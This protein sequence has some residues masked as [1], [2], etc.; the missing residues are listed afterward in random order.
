MM[1]CAALLLS[2]R[3][4]PYEDAPFPTSFVET[5]ETSPVEEMRAPNTYAL[6]SMS[7]PAFFGRGG[8]AEVEPLDI[9]LLPVVFTITYWCGLAVLYAFGSYV[10]AMSPTWRGPVVIWAV[11]IPFVVFSLWRRLPAEELRVEKLCH[12]I[13]LL[14]CGGYYTLAEQR[15]L[16]AE[17]EMEGRST[18]RCEGQRPPTDT[19]FVAVS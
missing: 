1:S 10:I 8:A 13:V 12:E 6:V 2:P 11:L 14:R 3:H 7:E 15:V 9:R 16:P 4:S 19:A 18:L 5:V 17:V